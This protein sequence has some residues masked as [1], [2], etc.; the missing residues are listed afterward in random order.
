[1]KYR[2][3]F[4]KQAGEVYLLGYGGEVVV[5]IPQVWSKEEGEMAVVAFGWK[6]EVM[7]ED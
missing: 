3:G 1:L 4:V 2:K 6:S 7:I 5:D